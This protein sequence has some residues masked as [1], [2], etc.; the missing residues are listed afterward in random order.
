MI[1]NALVS[2][3][4]WPGKYRL[5]STFTSTAISPFLGPLDDSIIS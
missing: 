1:K 3:R 4:N 5:T 2:E